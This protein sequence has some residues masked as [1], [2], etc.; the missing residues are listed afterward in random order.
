MPK[1]RPTTRKERRKKQQENY[2][3]GRSS[4]PYNHTP[5]LNASFSDDQMPGPS[6]EL[7]GEKSK[8]CLKCVTVLSRWQDTFKSFVKQGSELKKR[9]AINPYPKRS[10]IPPYRDLNAQNEWLRNNVF[11]AMGNYLFCAK[12]VC[13]AFHVSPQRIARQRA[14]KQN[15]FQSPTKEL[16]KAHVEEQRL[17]KYVVMPVGCDVNFTQW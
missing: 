15:Q 10:D 9:K 16:S 13:A 17:G 3:A 6:S 8:V 7:S 12:C 5:S 1:D 2:V 11:D 14:I 4:R